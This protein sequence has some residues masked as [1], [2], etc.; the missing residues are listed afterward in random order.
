MMLLVIPVFLYGNIEKKANVHEKDP[1]ISKSFEDRLTISEMKAFGKTQ[2]PYVSFPHGNHVKTLETAGKDCKACHEEHDG[3]MIFTFMRPETSLDSIISKQ[4][5]MDNYHNNCIGCHEKTA[6]KNEKTG[7]V[8]CG[9]CHLEEGVPDQPW[10]SAGFDNSLHYRHIKAAQTQQNSD[11]AKTCK[12]CHTDC[13]T[14][15]YEKNKEQSCRYC[16]LEQT[17]KD[18]SSFKAAGHSICVNCHLATIAGKKKAGPV[19]CKGCH[20][21]NELNKIEKVA[22]IPKLDRNQPEKLLIKTGN[23]P[24]DESEKSR[25]KFVSF[26]H[27]RHEQNN[28]TCRACHHADLN[29]C[30]KCHTL[31]GSKDGK[32]VTLDMA[33]HAAGSKTSCIGCHDERKSQKECAG[34]HELIRKTIRKKD[35]TCNACHTENLSMV[36]KT[37]NY[38]ETYKDLPEKI[39][40]KY[41]TDKYEAANFPHRMIVE[42]ISSNIKGSSL[43]N[44]F[45]NNEKTLC[46]GCHHNSPESENPPK[47]NHC[48][49]DS[50]NRKDMTKPGL[51]GAYHIQCMD[52]HKQMGIEKQGCTDCHKEKK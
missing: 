6:A 29:K 52:C 24:I 51:E 31:E 41:L 25:M 2:K 33:M 32:Q 43:A 22:S 36:K 45:H 20:D 9:Q 14:G 21:I 13:K 30:S 49:D 23:A 19:S 17:Q 50:L 16:H 8:T 11:M 26:D 40:I 39:E 42:K 47:C 34:C 28:A 44:H 4:E 1:L 18:V 5:L 10:A 3:K 38:P 35:Q 37:I 27:T 46:Q 15:I 12:Q 48:H 7:P